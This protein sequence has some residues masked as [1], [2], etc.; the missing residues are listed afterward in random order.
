MT[1]NQ[2]PPVPEPFA[3]AL[4]EVLA[5]LEADPQ[6]EAVFLGG[7]LA[8]GQCAE[9]SDVDLV[10]VKS[11]EVTCM[12]RYVTYVGPVQVQVIAGPPR[13]YDIWFKADRPT[14]TVVRQLATGWLL[15]DRSGLG[16][17]YQ[18]LAQEVV[19]RGLEAMTPPQV[20]SRR[21][22]LT[23][24]LDDVADCSTDAAQARW[25][26]A[27]GLA[28]AVE[29]AFLWHRRWTPKGKRALAE[30]EALPALGNPGDP[31]LADL[32]RRLLAATE[33]AEQQASFAALVDHVLAP[34]GGEMREPWTR[35]PEPVP[36]ATP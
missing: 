7:S 21:F 10:V 32:C 26:M 27:G 33:L 34:L 18:E 25:L 36:E 1:T 20:H 15:F 5:G 4:A 14:G 13:Q 6:V 11:S 16:G 17:R 24:L 30:I 29:T 22:L 31:T 19:E 3:T 23:E 9:R 8:L 2:P 28:Y 12:E 35:P